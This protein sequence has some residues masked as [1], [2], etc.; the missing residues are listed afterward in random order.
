MEDKT[1]DRIMTV[2]QLILAVLMFAC[3]GIIFVNHAI[4]HFRDW[5]IS[6]MFLLMLILSA[7]MLKMAVKETKQ[8]FN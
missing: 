2:F 7:W 1:P 5:F 4:I 3:M 6:A 8:A